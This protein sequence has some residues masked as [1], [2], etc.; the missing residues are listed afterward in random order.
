MFMHHDNVGAKNKTINRLFFERAENDAYLIVIEG[1]RHL[2]FS[3]ISLPGY[4]ELLQLPNDMLGPV[5][6][7][8]CLKIINTYAVAFFDKYLKGEDSE[9]LNGPSTDYPEVD[10]STRTQATD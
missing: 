1:T 10:I 6:G 4:G 2:N 5:D 9:L 7:S 3:D 8:Y